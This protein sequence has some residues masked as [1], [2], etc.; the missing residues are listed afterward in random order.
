MPVLKRDEKPS[1]PKH[2][3]SSTKQWFGQVVSE[4]TLEPHHLHLLTLACEARDRA[5]QA[6]EILA[7]EGVTFTDRFGSPR[8]RPE[9]A[10]ERDC[11]LAFARLVREL[12]LDTEA[13]PDAARP[14]SL[15]SNRRA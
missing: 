6:R 11:R 3:R 9:V 10:V 4:Y 8:A 13:T 14:P 5:E 15:R 2:L 7:R 1:P 12:D